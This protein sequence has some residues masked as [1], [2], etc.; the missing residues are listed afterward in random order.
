MKEKRPIDRKREAGGSFVI[1]DVNDGTPI[2]KFV[3][4]AGNLLALT[5]R[6][7]YE[8]KLADQ[9]DPER[10]NPN[11][12]HNVHRQVL[13]VGCESELVRRVFL[14]AHTLFDEKFLRSTIDH[15]QALTLAFDALENM[16]AMSTIASD[17][18]RAEQHADASFGARNQ[19][20][21]SI[22]LPAIG[23]VRSR[24]KTYMQKADHAAGALYEIVKLFYPMTRRRY[25]SGVLETLR[26]KYGPDDPFTLEMT[27]AVPFLMLV[28][29]TRDCLEHGNLKG[30]TITDFVITAE[31]KIER[32]VIAIDFRET[33]EPAIAIALFFNQIGQGLTK[34]IELIFALLCSKN[35]EP[36]SGF[37]VQVI[38]LD[39]HWQAAKHVRFAYGIKMN[40]Q[41]VPI[42]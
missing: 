31:G 25:W 40:G 20:E 38:E 2:R 33:K 26:A 39:E 12:P 28:R 19:R 18:D 17:F 36:C 21:G 37:P 42:G 29:N 34:A 32:P 14:S 11:L 13:S 15:E 27:R 9:I 10:T 6:G 30:V 16:T 3:K 24:C 1:G 22:M 5:D 8:I 7:I 41:M 23:D 35:T 4:M